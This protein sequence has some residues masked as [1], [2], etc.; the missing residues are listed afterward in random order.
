MAHVGLPSSR[1]RL[2][3]LLFFLLRTPAG[4]VLKEVSDA[5]SID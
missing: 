5:E 3:E 1:T 4:D 2:V